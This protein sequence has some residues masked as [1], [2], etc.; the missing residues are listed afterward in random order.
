[1]VVLQ[2]GPG[3][4]VEAESASS[5]VRI[6]GNRLVTSYLFD[7]VPGTGW[8]TLTYF[9]VASNGTLYADDVGTGGFQHLNKM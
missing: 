5:I 2:P 3:G 1:M 8:F 9:A 4:I 7:N 6:A